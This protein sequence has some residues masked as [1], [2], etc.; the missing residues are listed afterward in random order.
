MLV[1]NQRFG[2]RLSVALAV[3]FVVQLLLG[4]GLHFHQLG[5]HGQSGSDTVHADFS[6]EL[7]GDQNGLDADPISREQS[8]DWSLD[9]VITG[10]P[11]PI[12]V[13]A[14]PIDVGS[15]LVQAPQPPPRYTLP[16]PRD[17]PHA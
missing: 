14:A 5:D 3:V 17:P 7:H 13:T 15:Q 4:A 2:R 6:H 12:V 9:L 1:S 8:G 16:Q 10:W 11:Q